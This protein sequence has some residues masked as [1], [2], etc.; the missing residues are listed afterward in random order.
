MKRLIIALLLFVLF[1]GIVAAAPGV[2]WNYELWSDTAIGLT[3]ISTS[4]T[5]ENATVGH[6]YYHFDDWYT[7]TNTITVTEGYDGQTI[8]TQSV[9]A[10]TD[11]S[12]V[13]SGVITLSMTCP[14]IGVSVS[15]DTG[16]GVAS[17]GI[18]Q[19]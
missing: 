19:R 18:W 14:D 10:A 16:A 3:P 13:A 8:W 2:P 11:A 12:T 6:I 9:D 1:A 5:L 15:T 4:L 17:V 7:N